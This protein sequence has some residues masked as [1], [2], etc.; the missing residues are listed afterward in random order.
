MKKKIKLRDMTAEQWDTY[1]SKC[2]G[3]CNNCVCCFGNCFYSDR[4]T[5]W[6]NHKDFYTSKFL[7][8]EIEIDIPDILTK[9]EKW[10]LSAFIKSFRDKVISISKKIYTITGSGLIYQTTYFIDIQVDNEF[11]IYGFQIQNNMYEHMELDKKYTLED[12]GLWK[13]ILLFDI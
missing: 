8:Q 6:I 1:R 12:L 4:K 11:V 3:D 9:E 7:D 10:C 13:K 2:K 5:S